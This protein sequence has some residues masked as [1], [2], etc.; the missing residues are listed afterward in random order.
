VP[1]LPPTRGEKDGNAS[2]EEPLPLDIGDTAGGEGDSIGKGLP[3]GDKDNDN[4]T[5]SLGESAW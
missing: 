1:V 2:F 3:S 5:L 4:D